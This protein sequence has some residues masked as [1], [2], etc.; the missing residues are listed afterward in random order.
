MATMTIKYDN[1][2]K[3]IKNLLDSL[4]YS[5]AIHPIDEK[6]KQIAKFRSALRETQAIAN[7]IATKGT[8]GYK[9]LDDLLDED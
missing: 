3:I 1:R 2:N 8:K 6:D 5:G 4:I 9:T 7:D